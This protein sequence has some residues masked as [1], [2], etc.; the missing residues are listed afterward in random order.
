MGY[1]PGGCSSRVVFRGCSHEA[2]AS[3]FSRAKSGTHIKANS[4]FRSYT[5]M[6]RPLSGLDTV[7]LLPCGNGVSL[8]NK[9]LF[10]EFRRL[11][12]GNDLLSLDNYS[13][14]IV[15]VLNGLENRKHNQELKVSKK[16]C[17]ETFLGRST[18]G[19]RW[20]RFG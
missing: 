19:R 5:A 3:R 4:C 8:R 20:I 12:Q 2:R 6:S 16:N 10:F 15:L 17:Q 1:F 9:T 14:R 11:P 7:L 13:P 18:L